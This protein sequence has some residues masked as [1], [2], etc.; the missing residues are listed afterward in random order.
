MDVVYNKD[1]NS[2]NLESPWSPFIGGFRGIHF[3][4]DMHLK[5]SIAGS[6]YWN[7]PWPPFIRG[8]CCQSQII[9]LLAKQ[10]EYFQ[11]LMELLLVV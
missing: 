3:T 10:M 1:M 7:P 9:R 4:R 6:V 5:T 2:S 11:V 8:E